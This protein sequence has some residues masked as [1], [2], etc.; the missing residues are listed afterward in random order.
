MENWLNNIR[1]PDSDKNAKISKKILCNLT[2]LALGI[3]L[4]IF[5]KWLDNLSIDDTI[6]WQHL[7][8]I[9][10]LGNIFSEFGIWIFLAITISVLS[11][12]PLRASLNVFLF[13]LGMTVSYHLYTIA[14]SGFNPKSY[15]M[16]W[17]GITLV[18]PVLAFICWYGKGDGGIATAISIGMISVMMLISFGIGPWYFDFKSA[19][20]TL[21]FIGTC[22]VLYKDIKRSTI[23]VI[24]ALGLAFLIS[25]IF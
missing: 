9:L 6:W 10:D 24:G 11:K 20:D 16:I 13:F 4:G 3:M 2:I 14:F 17:Y 15:M 8:G 1:K 22:A 5:S 21:F 23:S 19:L 18:S 7:L 12:T 25:M